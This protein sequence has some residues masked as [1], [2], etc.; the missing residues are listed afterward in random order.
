MVIWLGI[1]V[2]YFIL[3]LLLI[4]GLIRWKKTKSISILTPDVTV[5]VAMRNEAL[6]LQTLITSLATQDYI[7]NWE[8]NLV[9][10][11]SEDNSLQVAHI[12]KLKF[13]HLKVHMLKS[14]GN[15][16]K[17]ALATGIESATG[18][19]IITTDADSE[20]PSGWMS[21][22][23]KSFRGNTQMVVGAVR[24]KTNSTFFSHIQAVEFASVMGTGLGMLGWGKPL[25]CNGASLAFRKSAFKEVKGYSGNEHI[26]SG[27][28]EFLMRKIADK[29]SKSIHAI[30]FGNNTCETTPSKAI[31]EFFDQR[32]RWA[33]KWRRNSSWLARLFAV[34]VFGF[35]VI[36]LPVM[37]IAL[38][39]KSP[40]L[41]A[42]VVLKI[43]LELILLVIVSKSIR[44]PFNLL[45]FLV[46]Q[47]IYP[48]YIIVVAPASQ[49]IGYRWKG[50][51]VSGLR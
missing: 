1:F 23:V 36:W 47:I 14:A 25:M 32:I 9:D 27:D 45:A 44:Q 11:H 43:L 3:L 35:Q 2:V 37:A 46:L 39:T 10:D 7:G 20:L 16:K 22:L 15:G 29:F 41:L 40:L 31:G 38:F 51:T 42:G 48:P 18:E 34:F 50:R 49:L 21:D 13:P 12:L 28:D 26:P 5:V 19:I 33:G 6:N 30:N 24:L 17:Q 4:S 8:L